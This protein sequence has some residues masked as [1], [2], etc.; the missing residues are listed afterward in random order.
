MIFE[1]NGEYC[2]QKVEKFKLKNKNFLENKIIKSFLEKIEH[3]ELFAEVICNPTKENEE[4][5]DEAFK[6]FYF[7]IRFTSYISSAIYFN[8]INFDKKSR[9]MNHRNPLTVDMP[10]GNEE[11]G[12]FKDLIVDT[13]ADIQIDNILQSE[14]IIDYLENPTLCDAIRSLTQKQQEVLNLAFVYNLSDT[15]IGMLTSKSQQSVSKIRKKALQEIIRY[16]KD[17]EESIH[18]H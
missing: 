11:D 15:K 10:I 12:T 4:R 3:N 7:N 17:R 14:R 18:D 1:T 6:R 5:L 13:T 2:V 8:A 16:L 9:K